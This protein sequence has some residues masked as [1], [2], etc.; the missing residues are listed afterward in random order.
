MHHGH[1]GVHD[2]D[3]LCLLMTKDVQTGKFHCC[4][5][6]ANQIEE[7]IPLTFFTSGIPDL[8]FEISFVSISAVA[9]ESLFGAHLA[10]GH[11]YLNCLYST[12]TSKPSDHD[13]VIPD[14]FRSNFFRTGMFDIITPN[15][16]ISRPSLSWS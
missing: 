16:I 3:L 1:T 11:Q 13:K 9:S 2:L 12:T 6:W 15:Q 4:N 7:H 5:H 14:F 8:Y 10:Q